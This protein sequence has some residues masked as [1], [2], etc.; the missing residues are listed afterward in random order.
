MC[1]ITDFKVHGLSLG[2]L[3]HSFSWQ[4]KEAANTSDR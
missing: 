1:G 2:P 4:A 3:D